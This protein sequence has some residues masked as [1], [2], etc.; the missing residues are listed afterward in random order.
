MLRSLEKSLEDFYYGVGK[1]SAKVQAIAT[2]L[3]RNRVNLKFKF[4]EVCLQKFSRDQ[5]RW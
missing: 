5:Y 4:I 1:Y 2:P 3:P